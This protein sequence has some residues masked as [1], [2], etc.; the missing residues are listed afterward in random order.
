M[1][2]NGRLTNLATFLA[3]LLLLIGVF[4]TEAI[5][6]KPRMKKIN[7]EGCIFIRNWGYDCSMLDG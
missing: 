7:Y 1:I 4:D 5:G 3:L 6:L 2:S